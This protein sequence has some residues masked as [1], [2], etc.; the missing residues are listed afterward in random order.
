MSTDNQRGPDGREIALEARVSEADRLSSPSVARNRDVIREAYLAH[1]PLAGRVLEIASGTGEHGL[2]ICEKADGVTWQPS[3]PDAISRRSVSAW[4]DW[5]GM[6][7]LRPPVDIDVTQADWWAAVTGEMDGIVCINMIHI[8]P[9]AAAEGLFAGAAALLKPGGK[10]FLYG[11]FKRHGQTAPS[12]LDFDA[13]LKARDPAW[14]VRD[15][16]EEIVPLAEG[17]GLDLE[18]VVEM[19]ANNLSVVF[20]R[21]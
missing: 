5:T 2:H 19:P 11:P 20:R 9:F 17:L 8:A 12:N 14:G 13:S 15:L 21:A 4:R 16:D 1:M 18:T 6:P 3:D 10:L 7:N